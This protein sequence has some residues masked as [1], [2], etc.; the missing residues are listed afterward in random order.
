[1]ILFIS[2]TQSL[3]AEI[4]Q[5]RY[6]FHSALLATR[7]LASE[8]ELIWHGST[9]FEYLLTNLFCCSLAIYLLCVKWIFAAFAGEY[10]K[11]TCIV[12]G[13]NSKSVAILSSQAE[14]RYA[15]V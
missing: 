12:N 13:T 11:D 3:Q 7:N 15:F 4:R 8:Q 2:D 10:I 1:M 14:S 6:G 5:T 9:F